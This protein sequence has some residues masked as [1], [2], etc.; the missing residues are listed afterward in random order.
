MWLNV[1]F[2]FTLNS[3]TIFTIINF[4]LKRVNQSA[5]IESLL[6]N[7][8]SHPSWNPFGDVVS[9]WEAKWLLGSFERMRL[10]QSLLKKTLVDFL[11]VLISVQVEI[12]WLLD[13]EVFLLFQEVLREVV[14][15]Y[16]LLLICES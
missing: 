10:T 4:L 16:G 6:F 12:K 1:N 11:W 13:R 2:L 7:F 15:E 8:G 14:L 3:L 9:H 5:L